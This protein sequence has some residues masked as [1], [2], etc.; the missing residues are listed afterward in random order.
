M[1]KYQFSQLAKY[2]YI[3]C[4]YI[5]KFI[6]HIYYLYI[7]F[8][9]IGWIHIYSVTAQASSASWV[10]NF[11]SGS[12]GAAE[13]THRDTNWPTPS[14]DLLAGPTFWYPGVVEAVWLQAGACPFMGEPPGIF[15]KV[16][17]NNILAHLRFSW[18][19]VPE[20]VTLILYLYQIRFEKKKRKK[21]IHCH[22]TP[23][24]KILGTR[25]I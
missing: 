8:Q 7:F 13:T 11:F 25:T 5:Y 21:Q 2:I 14:E 24:L 20:E 4:I 19:C 17:F 3:Y 15:Q 22:I 23:I 6:Y 9:P 12:A 10:W 16:G 1:C 18:S